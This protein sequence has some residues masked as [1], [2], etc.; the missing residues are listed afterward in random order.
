[1]LLCSVNPDLGPTAGAPRPA[2]PLVARR[3][4][5]RPARRVAIVGAGPA[6]LECATSIARDIEVVLFDE[7]AEIGGHLRDAARAPNRSGWNAL[8]D[9]YSHGLEAAGNVDVR[10]GAEAGPDLLR[11]FDRVVVAAGSA[12]VLPDLPGIDR[13]VSASAFVR[14]GARA[15]AGRTLMIVD[16]G[17]GWWPCASAVEQGLANGFVTVT[18]LTPASAF[19]AKLP[20]EGHVQLLARLR[21]A[22]LEIRPLMAL[23]SADA[24]SVTAR[25]VLSGAVAEFAADVLVVVGERRPRAWLELVPDR[26]SVQVIGDAVVPRRVQHAVSEGRAAGVAA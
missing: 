14:A 26:P 7:R 6:G 18:V 5:A 2:A 11:E 25:N 8:L 24:A 13:A 23:E 22:P 4:G 21:G 19:G 20:P 1:V 10:L 3:N 9:Y 17:F 15:P 12:E 16:D